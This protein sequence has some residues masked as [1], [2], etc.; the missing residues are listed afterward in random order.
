MIMGRD[1]E[2]SVQRMTAKDGTQRDGEMGGGG[3]GGGGDSDT[4]REEKSAIKAKDGGSGDVK[5]SATNCGAETRRRWR[6][7]IV[8]TAGRFLLLLQPSF[9][10]FFMNRF[11]SQHPFSVLIQS[12]TTL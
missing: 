9:V 2:S 5:E 4:R 1:S 11:L 10:G 6:C 8:S 12:F 7:V 3:R